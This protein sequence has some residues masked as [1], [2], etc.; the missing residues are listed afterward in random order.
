V[1]GILRAKLEV[2]QARTWG[3]PD[4]DGVVEHIAEG[5]A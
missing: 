1:S 2:N 4:A 3:T 5:V